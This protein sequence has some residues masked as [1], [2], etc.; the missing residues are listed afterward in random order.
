M[1]G[2]LLLR[3][4]GDVGEAL[5][6]S[7]AAAF[8]EAVSTSTGLEVMTVAERRATRRGVSWKGALSHHNEMITSALLHAR[9]EPPG[10]MC[11]TR[12]R[13][14]EDLGVRGTSA[15]GRQR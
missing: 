1:V 13:G 2:A 9:I 11:R 3:F 5:E 12:I 10:T 6:V 8:A 14:C 4:R 15:T 7:G